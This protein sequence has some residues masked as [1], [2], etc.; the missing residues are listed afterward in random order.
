MG[1]ALR[2]LSMW[3]RGRLWAPVGLALVGGG[4]I[5]PTTGRFQ[6][7]LVS[8]AAV[9][10]LAVAVALGRTGRSIVAPVAAL[11]ALA[12]LAALAPSA[13]QPPA[14]PTQD[15]PMPRVQPPLQR[16]EVLGAP[17]LAARGTRTLVR[18]LGRCVPLPAGGCSPRSGQLE[19][20]L[21]EH[22]ETPRTGDR[23][24]VAAFVEP[25]R[26]PKNPGLEALT[27]S[28]ARRA[29]RGSLP[30]RRVVDVAWEHRAPG[31]LRDRWA[32][33]RLQLRARLT[34]GLS[35]TAA[36]FARG[37]ALG[38]RGGVAT[39]IREAL[40]A[41]GT[42][43]VL[44]VSGAHVG[45]VAALMLLLLTPMVRFLPPSALRRCPWRV[46]QT[47]PLI[48]AIWC[49][50]ALAGLPASA[51]RAGAMATVALVWRALLLRTDL[52]EA[53]G[54][55]VVVL[56]V[57]DPGALGDVGLQLSLLGV[58]GAATGG[59]GLLRHW[60]ALTGFRRALV[61]LLGASVGAW[62]FTAPVTLWNF[63]ALALTAPLGN[64]LV[65]PLITLALLP[66]S[67]VALL[68]AMLP[69]SI[70]IAVLQF[71]DPVLTF[72][73]WPL[74]YAA[75]LP[76]AWLPVW[77]P[78]RSVG[79]VA[80]VAMAAAWLC[81]LSDRARIRW[82]GS[83]S[84]ATAALLL[85]YGLWPACPAPGTINV[86]MLDVGHGDA[87]L[88]R[89][90][91]GSTML[92][93]AGGEVGD[94]GRVGARAVLP[95]LAALGVRR[96]DVMVVSHP[97]PDHENGLLAIARALPVGELWSNGEPSGGAEHRA[98]RALLAAQGTPHRIFGP[99]SV[100]AFA[101]GSA[102]IDVIWPTP[103]RAPFD[104]DLGAND[105]SLVLDVRCGG[106]RMLLAGDI[107][108]QAEAAM[109][110]AGV[111]PEGIDVLKV[112]HHG[113]RT[114]S[115]AAFLARAR[116]R[117][118]IAGARAWGPLPFPNDDVIARYRDVGVPLWVTGDGAVA[119]RVGVGGVSA[120]QASRRF[121]LRSTNTSA[122]KKAS[123]PAAA[124]QMPISRPGGT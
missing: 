109:L 90:D 121:R 30:V 9:V 87:T 34:L 102:R 124:S 27:A 95:A 5:G 6:P 22:S 120:R 48:A 49:Y 89:F 54:V 69:P 92:V 77:T 70:D 86:D 63:G 62:S 45:A 46:W 76:P 64:L 110:A 68:A 83:A 80:G 104:P 94:N 53:L 119:L 105:N 31:G 84:I 44:A 39:E 75:T 115:T 18:W 59:A 65:V 58:L 37:L 82:G 117:I 11:V 3:M 32:M 8:V 51:C 61:T 16:V 12:L 113:S 1:A 56:V 73:S 111:V 103:L 114:S 15:L 33:W 38:D 13:A 42:A 10:L 116:P 81:L 57:I 50:I 85:G 19:L 72:A 7:F 14:I 91:D 106:A 67:M 28:V 66:L 99:T 93:D 112:P 79:L 60:P 52:H 55:A 36:G 35:P 4:V 71:I 40:R 29:L 118:A 74:S 96:I 2:Q 20:W 43:H 23:L 17:A 123:H 47:P 26:V 24:R 108:H 100:R 122:A 97:H 88:L 107:E 25:S 78:P 101:M 21:P 98:L 41:S